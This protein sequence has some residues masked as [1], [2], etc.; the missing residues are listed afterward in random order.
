[1]KISGQKHTALMKMFKWRLPSYLLE[2]MA[3]VDAINRFDEKFARLLIPYAND[4]ANRR[5][6]SGPF[7]DAIRPVSI[8]TEVGPCRFDDPIWLEDDDD[9]DE[10]G[11]WWS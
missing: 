9:D 10:D 8:D 1:M 7:A 2:D 4:I 5:T 3:I 6:Y 11:C